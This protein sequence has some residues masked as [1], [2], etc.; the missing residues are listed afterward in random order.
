MLQ[1]KALAAAGYDG[2]ITV[3][4]EAKEDLFWWSNN[5]SQWNGHTMVR[6]GSQVA[7]ETDASRAG[8]G[9]HSARERPQEVVGAGKNNCS[10]SMY[11]RGWLFCFALKVFLKNAEGVSVLIQ[12]DN[13]SVVSRIQRR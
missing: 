3:S 13:M 11:W 1:H 2:K 8:W 4:P 6:V 9:G 12:S 5:L 10:I 7:I